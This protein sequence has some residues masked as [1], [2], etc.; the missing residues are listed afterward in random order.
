MENVQLT[1]ENAHPNW[2]KDNFE[3]WQVISEIQ[4][5]DGLTPS[6]SVPIKNSGRYSLLSEQGLSTDYY[7]HIVLSADRGENHPA[8]L[9]VKYGQQ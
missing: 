4:I 7:S 2:F 1:K 5:V 9:R 8:S 6:K 3:K